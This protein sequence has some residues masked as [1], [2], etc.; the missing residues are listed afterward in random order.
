MLPS[1]SRPFVSV[2]SLGIQRLWS[3][4]RLLTPLMAAMAL[5][6]T[7]SAATGQTLSE[8]IDFANADINAFWAETFR[9]LG[10]K[11]YGP[12]SYSYANTVNTPCGISGPFNALYCPLNHSIYL[13]IPF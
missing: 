5:T 7:A 1:H 13:N 11:W 2:I 12:K 9:G 6:T 3:T 8:K 4:K 10:R